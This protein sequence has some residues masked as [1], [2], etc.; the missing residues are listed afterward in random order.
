MAAKL[1]LTGLKTVTL[2]GKVGSNG[3]CSF[4]DSG[5]VAPGTPGSYSE[6]LAYNTSTCQEKVLTGNLTKAELGEVNT[7]F[8]QAGASGTS[9]ATLENSSATSLKAGAV[10]PNFISQTSAYEKSAWIDPFFITITSMADDLTWDYTGSAWTWASASVH[11][12]EFAYDGWTNSGTPNINWYSGTY[13]IGMDESETFYNND[14]E[15]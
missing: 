13:N 12:Y 9:S 14:F 7:A 3:S 11:P 6:D 10:S 2:A 1:G 8:G 4:T 15:E 5:K